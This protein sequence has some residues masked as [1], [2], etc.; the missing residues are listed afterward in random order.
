MNDAVRHFRPLEP[1]GRFTLLL[2]AP[3]PASRKLGDDERRTASTIAGARLGALISVTRA[4]FAAGGRIVMPSDRGMSPIV[5]GIALDYARAQVTETRRAAE[6]P[7]VVVDTQW[8]DLV[9]ATHLAPYAQRGAV[10]HLGPNNEPVTPDGAWTEPELDLSRASRQLV[11]EGLLEFWKLAGAVFIGA[12]DEAEDEMRL[13]ER[14]GHD[15]ATI[16][17]SDDPRRPDERDAVRRIMGDRP[18]RWADRDDRPGRPA[19]IEPWAFVAQ[20]LMSRWTR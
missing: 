8:E 5:A 9:L 3:A 19:D 14:R 13:L 18:R 11:S 7:L 15:V 10:V 12:G 4:A 2:V 20:Q 17:A 16:A 6:P 1:H